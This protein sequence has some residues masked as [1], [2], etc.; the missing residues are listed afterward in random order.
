MQGKNFPNRLLARVSDAAEHYGAILGVG[1]T[2]LAGV[3]LYGYFSGN[4]DILMWAFWGTLAFVFG[5]P[6]IFMSSF[7]LAKL[8]GRLKSGHK[9][10][11]EI[12]ET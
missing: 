2:L 4:H 5:P 1:L 11:K 6:A 3:M 10:A 8:I 9:P 7:L 12:D